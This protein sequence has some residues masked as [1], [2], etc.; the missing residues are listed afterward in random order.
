[1]SSSLQPHGQASPSF[2]ISC[3][4][5]SVAQ[6]CLTLR[7]HGPQHDRHPCLSPSPR[8][9]P[10]SYSLHWWYHPT[11]LSSV[12]PFSFCPQSFPASGAFPN[13][14]LLTSDDQNTGASASASVLLTSIQ[15]W[16]PLRLTG[17]ISLQSKGLS[18]V[19]PNTKVCRHQ[20]FRCGTSSTMVQRH[21]LIVGT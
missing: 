11:V 16:F 21:H 5:Y 18:G 9:C 20:F 7:P 17:L 3:R 19:F 1:M 12:T 8:I 10:S 6:S 14:W 15:G 4:C 13:G 2:T